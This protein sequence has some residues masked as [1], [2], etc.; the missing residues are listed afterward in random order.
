MELCPRCQE[1]GFCL[2]EDLVNKVTQK[3]NNRIASEESRVLISSWREFA[4]K[5]SCPNIN[6]VDPEHLLY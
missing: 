6:E 5:E 4:R 3:A 2:F 1:P